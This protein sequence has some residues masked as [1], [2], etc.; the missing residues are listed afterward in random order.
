VKVENKIGDAIVHRAIRAHQDGTPWKCCILVPVLPGFPFSIDH[1]DASA[2]S[3]TLFQVLLPLLTDGKIRII[4]E[5]Q[6]R[7]IC[8]GP[9]SI[10][11]RLRKEGIDV[12]VEK[13]TRS[14][15]RN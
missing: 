13:K 10:F 8:R 12:S 1:S 7:T 9:N 5:C 6:N 15:I 11:G 2:V 3:G 4:V 14:V